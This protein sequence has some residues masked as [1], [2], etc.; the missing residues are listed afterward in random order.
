MALG[1][2]YKNGQGTRGL[3]RQEYGPWTEDRGQRAAESRKVEGRRLVTTLGPWTFDL[4]LR[5]RQAAERP[6][7]LRRS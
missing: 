5:D 7:P 6:C 3:L 4:G 2:N 1:R